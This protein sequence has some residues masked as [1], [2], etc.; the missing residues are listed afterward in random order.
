MNS[1]MQVIFVIPDFIKRWENVSYCTLVRDSAHL[2]S[3]YYSLY[4]H[5][6]TY[7]IL[8]YIVLHLMLPAPTPI[9]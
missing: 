6:L 3:V 5:P 8:T 2:C 9:Y 1:L 7:V 4:S